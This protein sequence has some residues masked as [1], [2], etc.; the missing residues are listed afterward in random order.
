MYKRSQSW[1]VFFPSADSGKKKKILSKDLLF[2]TLTGYFDK[3]QSVL[4]V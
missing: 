4:F 1:S 2:C 3:K